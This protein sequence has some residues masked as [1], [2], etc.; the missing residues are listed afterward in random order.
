MKGNLGAEKV[1]NILMTHLI[2]EW[3]LFC[4]WCLLASMS[5]REWKAVYNSRWNLALKRGSLDDDRRDLRLKG[6]LKGDEDTANT[7]R[8]GLK[9]L[10]T[11]PRSD[12]K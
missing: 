6:K 4:A 9:L 1:E 12:W 5:P 8:Y 11:I 3:G 7:P 2:A 10:A